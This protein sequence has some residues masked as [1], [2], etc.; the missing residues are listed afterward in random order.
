MS[1]DPKLGFYYYTPS[2]GSSFDPHAG[3]KCQVT[4]W[5]ATVCRVRFPDG[6]SQPVRRSELALAG[7]APNTREEFATPTRPAPRMNVADRSIPD[8][9]RRGLTWWD[10]RG[11][12]E[13]K[14][15]W[16][17]EVGVESTDALIYTSEFAKLPASVQK[18]L[19]GA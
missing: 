7:P 8:P 12:D 17:R 16:L 13:D 4:D 5:G 6:T 11:R 2:A 14:Q 19:R 3:Q 18:K 10:L 9:K 15:T 1:P